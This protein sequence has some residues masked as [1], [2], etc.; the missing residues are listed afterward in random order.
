MLRPVRGN[1]YLCHLQI[2]QGEGLAIS[3]IFEYIISSF[4]IFC[5]KFHED[6][7]TSFAVLRFL[8]IISFICAPDS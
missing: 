1:I 8:M 5:K 2:W 4:S 7:L 6:P 3:K